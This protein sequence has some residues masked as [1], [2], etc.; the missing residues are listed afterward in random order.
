MNKSKWKA[1]MEGAVCS[2]ISLALI[3]IGIFVPSLVLWVTLI[4]GIPMMYLSLRHGVRILVASWVMS[5][6]VLYC[7]TGNALGAVLMGWMCFL[8]GMVLGYTL[9]VRKHFST[10]ILSGAAV[11]LIGAVL[12]LALFNMA[13]DGRGIADA[14]DHA[15]ADSSQQMTVMLSSL[16]DQLS[17]SEE[18]L[19]ATI[20]GV[21]KA[22][23]ETILLYLPAFLIGCS[24]V[25]SYLVFMLSCFFLH[26]ARPIRIIYQPF[27]MIRAPKTMC[28]VALVLFLAGAFTDKTTVPMAAIRNMTALFSAYFTLCGVSV[29]DNRLRKRIPSGYARGVIYALVVCVG[30]LFLGTLVQI[31]RI[32]GIIDGFT[33][34]KARE[35][36]MRRG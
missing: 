35:E 19:Q 33:G 2:F 12:Q 18:D 23:K 3:L 16:K 1:L 36:W 32:L 11:L 4:S 31:M 34:S 30:Y 8:P 7:I 27:W 25:M 24:V 21:M 17:L 9:R 13:G 22:T 10:I 20:D 28:Y 5:V 6:L 14:V 29:V 15:V 26:R